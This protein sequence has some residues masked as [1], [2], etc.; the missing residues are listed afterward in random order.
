MPSAEDVVAE[1][2]GEDDGVIEKKS[3]RICKMYD[4]KTR[5]STH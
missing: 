4:L 1:S 2:G 3:T 5:E